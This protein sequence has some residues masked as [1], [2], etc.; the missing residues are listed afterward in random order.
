[1]AYW[2]SDGERQVQ[3]GMNQVAQATD[4][5]LVLH[6]VNLLCLTVVAQLQPVLHWSVGR[7]AAAH[8]N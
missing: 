1:M 3:L 2:C 5:T 7:D 8:A 6:R 4:E